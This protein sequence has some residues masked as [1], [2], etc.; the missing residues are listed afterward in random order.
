MIQSFI[1]FKLNGTSHDLCSFSFAENYFIIN[2]FLIDVFK[3][4]I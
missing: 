2:Y 1:E 4:K 3:K